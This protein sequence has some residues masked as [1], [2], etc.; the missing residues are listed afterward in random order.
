VNATRQV[1]QG[2][3]SGEVAVLTHDEIGQLTVAF[4]RMIRELALKDKINATFG[5]YMDPRLVEG[6][7]ERQDLTGGAG[8]R[9]VLTVLF[10]DMRG[11]T[12]L[13]EQV[14]PVSLVAVL[15]RYLGLMAEE[16]KAQHGVIDKFIGDSVMAFFGPPFVDAAEQGKRA[17]EAALGQIRRFEEFRAEVPALIG[18]RQFVPDIGIRI[19]IATGEVIVGNIG[20]QSAMNYTVIGDTV[21][22]A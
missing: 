7:I 4:N 6:L 17:C 20:S 8:D 5:R 10:C 22:A 2:S 15:N 21:N 1:E 13:S 16:V 18:F 12:H 14:T 19:G 9:R 11:F 3:F